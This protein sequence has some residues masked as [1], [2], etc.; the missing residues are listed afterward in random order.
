MADK[1]DFIRSGLS[2]TEVQM[3]KADRAIAIATLA[4]IRHATSLKH[5]DGGGHENAYSL[6]CTGLYAL[7]A[8]DEL[9]SEDI[10]MVRAAC[11]KLAAEIS[12]L[13]PENQEP[14]DG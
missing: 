14:T 6:A 5:D 1:N 12:V 8:T 2:V 10:R 9:T 11:P 4:Q 3:L 13:N 7:H